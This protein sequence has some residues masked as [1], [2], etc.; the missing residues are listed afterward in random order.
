[1]NREQAQ[2]EKYKKVFQK[3]CILD[4]LERFTLENKKGQKCIRKSKNVLALIRLDKNYD[5]RMH[6]HHGKETIKNYRY[7]KNR[8]IWKM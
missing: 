6:N 8:L 5:I 3:E 1:M 4:L 7:D 2:K